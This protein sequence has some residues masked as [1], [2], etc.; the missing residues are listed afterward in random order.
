M[1]H[2][3]DRAP[4]SETPSV[5]TAALLDV[6]FLLLVYFIVTAAS[7]S[8]EAHVS[9][10]LPSPNQRVSDDPIPE[11]ASISVT[12]DT[13]LYGTRAN[14]RPVTMDKLKEMLAG[15]A[16]YDPEAQLFVKASGDARQRDVIGVLDTCHAVGL[17]DFKL[18]RLK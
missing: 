8:A 5:P 3:R 4:R 2:Q 12:A 15:L 1:I 14:Q 11:Y 16:S 18:M 6:I 7:P 13:I 17:K 10:T 9:T